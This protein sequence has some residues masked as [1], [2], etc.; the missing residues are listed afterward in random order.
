[1]SRLLVEAEAIG[2][3]ALTLIEGGRVVLGVV[4]IKELTEA[5]AA[6]RYGHLIVAAAHWQVLGSAAEISERIGG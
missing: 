3:S 1:M 4:E 2:A 6:D 5:E